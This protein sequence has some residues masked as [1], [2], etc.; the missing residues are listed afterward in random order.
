MSIRQG[1][2]YVAVILGFLSGG[3]SIGGPCK[4]EVTHGRARIT[5]IEADTSAKVYAVGFDFIRDNLVDTL[6]GQ[7]TAFD[8]GCI[9]SGRVKL[10]SSYS[11]VHSK[12]TTNGGCKPEFYTF[13]DLSGCEIK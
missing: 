10:D 9:L 4:Y 7:T 12:I 5:L 11:C 13:P 1:I 2:A 8:T 3:C 6:T